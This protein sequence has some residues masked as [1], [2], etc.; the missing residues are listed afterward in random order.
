VKRCALNGEVFYG[1]AHRTDKDCVVFL[2]SQLR[3]AEVVRDHLRSRLSTRHK[4]AVI[5]ARDLRRM[6]AVLEALLIVEALGIEP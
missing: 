3:V 5:R 6:R 4:I 2:R 1:R